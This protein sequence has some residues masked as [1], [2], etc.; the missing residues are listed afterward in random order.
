MRTS[1][2]FL[3]VS[4]EM[5]L[6]LWLVAAVVRAAEFPTLKPTYVPASYADDSSPYSSTRPV[7]VSMTNRLGQ[8]TTL[9][10]RTPV[11]VVDANETFDSKTANYATNYDEG[12]LV[13]INNLPLLSSPARD[14]DLLPISSTRQ[15][16]HTYQANYPAQPQ[17]RYAYQSPTTPIVPVGGCA[18]PSVVNY[19]PA[20]SYTVPNY[21]TPVTGVPQTVYRP[22]QLPVAPVMQPNVAVSSGIYGQPVI[23]RPG[24]PLRNVWRYLT[25]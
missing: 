14:E 19:A 10:Y 1:M 22:V 5:A 12:E 23:Y 25:P 11:K 17:V 16:S 2:K 21:A 3:I 7:R 8:V 20:T 4:V 13:P 24:Q 6:F 9:E 15:V 18:A